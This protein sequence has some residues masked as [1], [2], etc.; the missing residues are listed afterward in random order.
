MIN[1]RSLNNGYS[2]QKICKIDLLFVLYKI[3][4][5][6][7]QSHR[8]FFLYSLIVCPVHMLKARR[9]ELIS[10]YQKCT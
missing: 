6:I 3:Y 4:T 10:W 9:K 7:L 1:L 2:K 8:W 5:G